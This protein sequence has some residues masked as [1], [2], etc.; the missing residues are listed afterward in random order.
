MSSSRDEVRQQALS[1][2]PQRDP[3]SPASRSSPPGDA[4]MQDYVGSSHGDHGS[5]SSPPPRREEGSRAAGIYSGDLLQHGQPVQA[6]PTPGRILREGSQ[7]TQLSADFDPTRSTPRDA[8]RSC[9]IDTFDMEEA[10]A[11]LTALCASGPSAR[12][13]GA[14][15][16][17]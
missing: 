9:N 7:D 10:Q 8:L 16:L 14:V 1:P 12:I 6:L 11:Q 5:P 15:P 2:H 3:V 13:R 4:N 17:H